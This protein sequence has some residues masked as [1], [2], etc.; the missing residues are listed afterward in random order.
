L[1]Q[2]G[3]DGA[4]PPD[5][6]MITFDDAWAGTYREGLRILR[7]RGLPA[8][9]FVNMGTVAGDPDLAAIRRFERDHAPRADALLTARLDAAAGTRVLEEARARYAGDAGFAAYQ[10]ETATQEDLVRA[11]AAGNV[12]FA[13]HLY[14]H[15]DLR[16]IDQDLFH[17]SYERNAEA[18]STYPNHVPAFA[19]PHGFAGGAGLDPVAMAAQAGARVLFTGTGNQNRVV[20]SPVIDRLALPPEPA[21]EQ[22][23]WY[24]THRRRI[25]GGAA[26]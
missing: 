11:A 14:H 12:W 8:L 6:A 25:L 1:A 18:L 10:G 20:D 15:W 9:C 7:E 3:G 22:A 17:A 13:S 4:L 5:A 24:A 23:W 19:T 26:S 21:D 2:L 16:E